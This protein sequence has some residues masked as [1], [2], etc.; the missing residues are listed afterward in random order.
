MHITGTFMFVNFFSLPDD[1]K[2]FLE[3]QTAYKLKQ[4]NLLQKQHF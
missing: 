3:L 1:K 2:L 4:Y